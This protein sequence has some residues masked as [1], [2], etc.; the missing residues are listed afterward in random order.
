[1]IHFTSKE[2]N[3]NIITKLNAIINC[4]YFLV[5]ALLHIDKTKQKDLS[6]LFKLRNDMS[7]IIKFIILQ[8]LKT[9]TTII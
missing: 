5:K 6:I 9:F 8:T 1:M 4:S 3:V 7:V 2:A